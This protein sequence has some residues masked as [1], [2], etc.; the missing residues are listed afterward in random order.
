MFVIRRLLS[1][2]RT[3]KEQEKIPCIPDL[4][5]EISVKVD[6]PLRLNLVYQFSA[7]T[8]AIKRRDNQ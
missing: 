2:S 5:P 1:L 4:G 8:I 6:R 7:L 3:L